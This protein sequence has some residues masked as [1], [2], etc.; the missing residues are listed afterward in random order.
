MAAGAALG[1]MSEAWWCPA[2]RI[3]GEQ[4]DGVPMYRLIL[5]ERARPGSLIVDGSGHRFI[6][7]AQNYNDLGRSLQ[8][9]PRPTAP[10]RSRPGLVAPRRQPQRAS[11]RD[12]RAGRG[13]R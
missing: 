8:I 9:R 6:D 10:E 3:P 1:T 2:I 4:I 5:A 7:E 12:R 13:P 11:G